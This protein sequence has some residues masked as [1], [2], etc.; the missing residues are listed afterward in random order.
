VRDDLAVRRLAL[1]CDAREHRRL[2]PAPVLVSSLQ[3]NV[4][5]ERRPGV[6]SRTAAWVEPESNQPSSVSVSFV[7]R[8]SPSAD[9][10]SPT[11]ECRRVQLVPR[12][13]P[14]SKKTSPRRRSFPACRP[15]YDRPHSKRRV[16]AGPSG[17]GARCT[18]RC[19]R[20]S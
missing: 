5:R 3:I 8:L 15:A 2:E 10:Q 7:K 17:A 20:G 1:R 9:R 6:S 16:S 4:G 18:S 19:A 11:A 13:G 14:F 12:V